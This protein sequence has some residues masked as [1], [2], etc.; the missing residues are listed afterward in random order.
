M[1]TRI[2]TLGSLIISLLSVTTP[3]AHAAAVELMCELGKRVAVL[4]NQQTDNAIDLKWQGQLYHL[5]RV[6]T[7]TGA[8][9][10]ED[11][12]SGLVWISIP[13]K[14]MLLDKYR[15]EPM[16]N[17]CKARGGNGRVAVQ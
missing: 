3:P 15:G 12:G 10:F 9:R 6:A 5:L 7:S 13:S 4:G 8:N 17:E 14:S 1:Q 16:A 11:H 2:F